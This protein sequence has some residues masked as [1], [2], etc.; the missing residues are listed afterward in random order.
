MHKRQKPPPTANALVK[1]ALARKTVSR[2]HAKR[3]QCKASRVLTTTHPF[4]H[5]EFIEPFNFRKRSS[6]QQRQLQIMLSSNH[7]ASKEPCRGITMPSKNKTATNASPMTP[8][9]VS[10]TQLKMKGANKA[11]DAKTKSQ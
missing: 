4:E 9:G 6:H 3:I 10:P 8:V 11:N 1:N 2:L 7:P 5:P